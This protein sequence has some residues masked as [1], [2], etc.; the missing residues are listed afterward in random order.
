M[1]VTVTARPEKSINGHLTK[2]NSVH[3]PIN[4]TMQRKD[5]IVNAKTLTAAGFV[6]LKMAAPIPLTVAVGQKVYFFSGT[7]KYT[8]TITS[9]S[10]LFITTNGTIAGTI[11][12]GSLNW[13]D[14]YKNYYIETRILN[15]DDSGTYV[16]LGNQK[17][18]IDLTGEATV[19][20]QQW[21][22]TA[23]IFKNNFLY[24]QIN[25][26][27]AGEGSKFSIQYREVFNGVAGAYTSISGLNYW[28]NSAKQIQQIYGSNMGDF[29]PTLDNARTSKAKFQS[30]FNK[31]TYFVNYPFSLNFIYSDNLLNYQ[32]IRRE[33]SRD[34]NGVQTNTTSDNLITTQRFFVN[35]LMLKGGYASNVKTIDIWL[36]TGAVVVGNPTEFTGGYSTG[37][38]FDPFKPV[39]IIKPI[40]AVQ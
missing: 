16:N 9:I 30:V 8:W 12:G 17:N 14:A 31:P 29:T 18:K 33:I 6:K 39:E 1:S 37:V 7:Q 13:V 15:V 23:V 20:V 22:K 28:T 36:E 24:N 11:F 26:K 40:T 38:L 5:A 21:L 25:K 3:Q 10:G 32:I 2:W 4:F 19:N 27:Q 35:R 34:I